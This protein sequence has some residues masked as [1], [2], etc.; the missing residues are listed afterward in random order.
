MKRKLSRPGVAVL[1][2]LAPACAIGVIVPAIMLSLKKEE[3]NVIWM[4]QTVGYEGADFETTLNAVKGEKYILKYDPSTD[5]RWTNRNEADWFTAGGGG[6][7]NLE[8]EAI[9]DVVIKQGGIE[10]TWELST[11]VFRPKTN[12]DKLTKTGGII[13]VTFKSKTTG[14]LYINIY[15]SLYI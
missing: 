7:A 15:N 14:R 12:N 11:S 13:E 10:K 2:A 4:T 3:G 9:E 6:L 1:A 8:N 5:T